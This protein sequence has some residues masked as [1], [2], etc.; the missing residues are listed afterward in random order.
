MRTQSWCWRRRRCDR[1]L[2]RVSR[3]TGNSRIGSA[4][5]SRATLVRGSVKVGEVAERRGL[6][7]LAARRAAA[8]SRPLRR[9]ARSH[10]L[11]AERARRRRP[12]R[13]ATLR[14]RCGRALARRAGAARLRAAS[15]ACGVA[16]LRAAVR[17]RP[18]RSV[19]VGHG[20]ESF[21]QHLGGV[22]RDHDRR[23]VEDVRPA[24]PRSSAAPLTCCRRPVRCSIFSCVAGGRAAASAHRGEA[25]RP[26]GSCPARR[27][28]ARRPTPGRSRRLSGG[29][30]A[31]D[32]E[33]E[34]RLARPLLDHEE[35][36][37]DRRPDSRRCRPSP[38]RRSGRSRRSRC[39]DRPSPRRAACAPCRAAGSSSSAGVQRRSSSRGLLRSIV[40]VALRC[41]SAR[42]A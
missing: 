36:A 42:W 2:K 16:A 34:A 13:R 10:A 23:L 3:R 8:R 6:D 1:A 22:D 11:A 27:R 12:A 21:A 25:R 17:A 38:R 18:A 7:R 24:R 15:C 40:A 28:A 35:P 32:V 20:R 31:V 9:S 29:C 37:R 33:A 14:S 39:R 4:S 41:Q 26:A 5:S 19:E 30:L